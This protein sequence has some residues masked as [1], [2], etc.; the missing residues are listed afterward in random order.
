MKKNIANGYLKTFNSVNGRVGVKLPVGPAEIC[1]I[2]LFGSRDKGGLLSDGHARPGMFPNQLFQYP[3][4]IFADL[5]F[6]PENRCSKAF[7]WG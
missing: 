5:F 3:A 1:F 7:L 6:Y 4:D 2:D